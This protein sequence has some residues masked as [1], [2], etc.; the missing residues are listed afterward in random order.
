MNVNVR[1]Y[2]MSSVA[3]KSSFS[4]YNMCCMFHTHLNS[5]R[6]MNPFMCPHTLPMF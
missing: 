4:L 6:V 1:N 2:T 5:Y 3:G